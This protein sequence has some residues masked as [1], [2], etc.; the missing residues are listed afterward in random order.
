MVF[1]E[2]PITDPDSRV[3][4]AIAVVSPITLSI[5]IPKVFAALPALFKLKAKSF[6]VTA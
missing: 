6:D 2:L 1:S 4:V 3:A 5:E